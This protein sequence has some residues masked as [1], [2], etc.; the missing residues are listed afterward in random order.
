MATRLFRFSAARQLSKPCNHGSILLRSGALRHAAI[1][2]LVRALDCG[3]RGPPFEPGWR[4]QE[5]QRLSKN[6]GKSRQPKS[7][8]V[9]TVSPR[10]KTGGRP[11]RS[12]PPCLGTLAPGAWD[13]AK[14]ARR[15]AMAGTEYQQK[16]PAGVGAAPRP[17]RKPRWHLK[18]SDVGY[19]FPAPRRSPTN[20]KPS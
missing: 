7:H 18:V 5:I 13:C 15:A 10:A 20:C 4:Y 1:A 6:S 8:K 9:T 11:S 17:V 14:E 2:Q 12:R 3:S 16:H 19:F